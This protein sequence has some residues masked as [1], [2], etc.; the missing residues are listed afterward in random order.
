MDKKNIFVVTGSP[1]RNSNSDLL[2]DA[3]I[4]GAK[5]AGHT[6][7]RF[8]AGRKKLNGCIACE[9]CF[10]KKGA[11]SVSSDFS[12][13]A[14][15]IEQADVIVLASPLY[16][17]SF[18]AQIK[19]FI[20]KLFSFHVGQRPSNIKESIL[21]T[22]GETTEL[23]DFDALIKTYELIA[24]FQGWKDRGQLIVPNVLAKKEIV[25][26]GQVYLQKAKEMGNIL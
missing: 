21:L 24:S 11:C 8:D 19:A 26:K 1:R 12:E 16:F 10:S 4:E 13:I 9:T 17:F 25:T 5:E 6:V 22:C 23:S 2:A 3:F 15:L 18:T 20:D 7:T 14:P